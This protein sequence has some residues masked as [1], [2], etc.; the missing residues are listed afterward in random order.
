MDEL[1]TIQKLDDIIQDLRMDGLHEIADQLEIE[2]QKIGSQFNKAEA[3][4]Q[5]DIEELLDE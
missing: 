3:N 1:K 2:K 4:S 5:I